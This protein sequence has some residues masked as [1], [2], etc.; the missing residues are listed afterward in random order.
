VRRCGEANL[1]LGSDPT[2]YSGRILTWLSR[3]SFVQAI[4]WA[5]VWPA[6]VV[7]AA[8][9]AAALVVVMKV[10][11]DLAF[12]WDV[13]SVGPMPVWLGATVVLAV[14]LLGPSVV[15]LALWRVARR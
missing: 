4:R 10:R 12:A 5:L 15:F 9:A 14:V 11:G 8:L 2:T 13:D 3:L 1:A 6:L 7:T